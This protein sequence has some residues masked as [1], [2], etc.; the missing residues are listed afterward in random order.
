MFHKPPLHPVCMAL[1]LALSGNEA[2]ADKP[3]AVQPPI[4]FKADHSL[5][6]LKEGITEL[7]GKVEISQGN[8]LIQADKAILRSVK[9]KVEQIELLG[10]PAHW[11]MKPDKGTEIQAQA[12]T[13]RYHVRSDR[14]ELEGQAEITQ[15]KSHAQGEYFQLN[16]KTGELLGG[17]AD[18]NKGR[19]ELTLPPPEPDN[20]T[21]NKSKPDAPR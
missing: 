3:G 21:T 5:S 14:I 19:V 20:N 4:H 15:G 7:E 17:E 2:L 8:S 9:G 11:Q 1:L 18:G 10:Q 6:R 16:R 12:L 13:I